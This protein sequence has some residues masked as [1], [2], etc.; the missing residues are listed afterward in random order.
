MAASL[1]SL[2]EGC[3]PMLTACWQQGVSITGQPA[4]EE[5][6]VHDDSVRPRPLVNDVAA[7]DTTV[8]A[9]GG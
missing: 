8:A 3:H 6:F 9:G 5:D 1:L 7:A 4:N 2:S